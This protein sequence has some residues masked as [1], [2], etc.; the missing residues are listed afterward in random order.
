MGDYED[1][2]FFFNEDK[3]IHFTHIQTWRHS[4][5]RGSET[6]SGALSHRGPQNYL[7]RTL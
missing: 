3:K 6:L 2:S 7:G 1:L 4:E 5:E